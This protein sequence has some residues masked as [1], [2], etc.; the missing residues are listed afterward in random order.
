MKSRVK[1]LALVV[2]LLTA[3]LCL[4]SC[5]I[6]ELMASVTGV[7]KD[8]AYTEWQKLST[9]G[10][11]DEEGK[12]V[13]QA[14]HVT[15][16][17]NPFLGIKYYSDKEMQEPINEDQCYIMP[18]HCIYA[19]VVSENNP[20]TNLYHFK[21]FRIWDYDEN[22]QRK[23]ELKW[24]PGSGDLVFMLPNE[25]SGTDIGVEP[26]GEYQ[27]RTLR[28]EDHLDNELIERVQESSWTINGNPTQNEYYSVDPVEPYSVEYHFD[29]ENY[30]F[31]SS[32]PKCFFSGEGLV[33][34]E[35]MEPTE[36]NDT[37]SV[38]LGRYYSAT[39]KAENGNIEKVKVNGIERTD[40]KTPQNEMSLSKL[41]DT[42]I[43]VVVSNT[44]KVKCTGEL[45]YKTPQSEQKDGKYYITIQPGNDS[46]F[47][48]NPRAYGLESGTLKFFVD[49]EEITT[50]KNLTGGK[51]IEYQVIDMGSDYWMPNEIKPIEV[52]GKETEVELKK[53]KVWPHKLVRI[54]LPQV[55][56]GTV[57][58]KADG[59][60]I[61]GDSIE[62]YCGTVISAEAN[63]WIGW[64]ESK[65]AI[66][67]QVGKAD[68]QSF[69]LNKDLFEE[70]NKPRFTMKVKGNV[71]KATINVSADDLSLGQNPINYTSG[72]IF[73]DVFNGTETWVIDKEIGSINDIQFSLQNTEL[74]EGTDAIHVTVY[75]NDVAMEEM[76]IP[77]TGSVSVPIYP[78]GRDELCKAIII[79]LEATSH[80]DVDENSYVVTSITD[81]NNEAIVSEYLLPET[82]I[83]LCLTPDEHHYFV[84]ANVQNDCYV[85]E[86]SYTE[87]KRDINNVFNSQLKEKKQVSLISK[88]KYGTTIYKLNG[89]E[90]T[91]TILMKDTDQLVA[92]YTITD[93]QYE[94]NT[95]TVLVF[96]SKVSNTTYSFNFADIGD[97]V[98]VED[99]LDIRK[100]EN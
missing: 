1:M 71:H 38:T 39:L 47:T 56:G 40:L 13:S 74:A 59:E 53:I 26:I 89:V 94:I 14:I 32:T 43:I 61:D 72:N 22:G 95:K 77:A 15:F 34:F 75:R 80:F 27:Q 86:L 87:Y 58:Y 16:G 81:K 7:N 84:G 51:I 18:G 42:D 31:V 9:D 54:D 3:I 52:N 67:Y 45:Q 11:L 6:S 8:P 12:Y 97:E 25:Y 4:S 64:K 57:T 55:P 83:K 85:R 66:D 41:K 96:D 92:E 91:G 60:S 78:Q 79:K 69:P 82:R 24:Y 44:D 2:A 100:K 88:G 68:V 36:D 37:Y 63:P 10:L 29:A 99:K 5:S 48:L 93:K 17:K 98:N 62:L 20:Y 28:F 19:E 23:S 90:C 21:T 73:A 49:G 50:K 65:S 33:C 46:D 76:D 70:T 35:Q 30:Y